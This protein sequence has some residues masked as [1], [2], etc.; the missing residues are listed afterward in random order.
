V[1]PDGSAFD[2]FKVFYRTA[3]IVR[4][5]NLTRVLR[6]HPAHPPHVFRP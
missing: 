4:G 1:F 5:E 2:A 3:K 6:Y